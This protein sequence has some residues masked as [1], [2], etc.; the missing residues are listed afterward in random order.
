MYKKLV[1]FILSL[2]VIFA[3]VPANVFA[4]ENDDVIVAENSEKSAR[5][6]STNGFTYSPGDNPTVVLT[7]TMTK[8]RYCGVATSDCSVT[9]NLRKTDGSDYRAFTFA[10]TG[11]WFTLDRSV[12]PI[13]PGSYKIE[14]KYQTHSNYTLFVNFFS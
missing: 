9:I 1:S 4:A 13:P 8:V 5:T 7:K 3:C 11:E 2:A 12:N 10:C 6:T 14:V